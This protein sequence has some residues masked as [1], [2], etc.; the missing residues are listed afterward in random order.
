MHVDWFQAAEHSASN[1]T[2][3]T[4]LDTVYTFLQSW[5]KFLQNTSLVVYSWSS[6][7]AKNPAASSALVERDITLPS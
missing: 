7:L 3:V 6:I 2:H 1:Y 4:I 5:K